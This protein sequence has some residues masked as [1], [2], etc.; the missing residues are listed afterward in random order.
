VQDLRRQGTGHKDR[1]LTR[2]YA[3]LSITAARSMVSAPSFRNCACVSASCPDLKKDTRVPDPG[4]RALPRRLFTVGNRGEDHAD[5][6]NVGRSCRDRNRRRG[7]LVSPYALVVSEPLEGEARAGK[8]AGP[9]LLRNSNPGGGWRTV[10]VCVA[11]PDRYR[12]AIPANCL[13]L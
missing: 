13:P 6:C 7:L 2:P 10:P 3:V 1:Q 5:S 8:P 12:F 11:S 9:F 4:T